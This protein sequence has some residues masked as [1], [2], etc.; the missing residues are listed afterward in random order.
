[1]IFRNY[2]KLKFW[3]KRGIE[4]ATRYRVRYHIPPWE[5]EGVIFTFDDGPELC[6]L[7]VLDLLDKYKKRAIFF[8][9]ADQVELYPQIAREIIK[10]GHL[11]GLHCF[12][13]SIDS[14]KGLSLSEFSRQ[15]KESLRIIEKICGIKIK[16]FRPSAGQIS[17]VQTIWILTHKMV[18]FLW[19]CNVSQSGEFNFINPNSNKYPLIVLL[20][21]RHLEA[22]KMSLKLLD[23]SKK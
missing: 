10:R 21:D 22:I 2:P 7:E 16:Y 19:S 5:G 8:L 18:L 11:I 15:I 3:L 1:M 9:V 13:R 4:I 23:A 14:M 12:S 6:T 17:L 20:H